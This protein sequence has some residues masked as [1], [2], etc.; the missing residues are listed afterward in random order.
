MFKKI[1][2]LSTVAIMSVS[3][4]VF[5]QPAMA[6]KKLVQQVYGS[7][8]ADYELGDYKSALKKLER[9]MK[10]AD[11]IE[12][13]PFERSQ[14][15]LTLAET[16]RSLGKYKEAEKNFNLS[17]EWALK[18]G[19]KK[20]ITLSRVYNNMA[21]L[22][23]ENG[24]YAKAE[25]SWL[26]AEEI[27]GNF[28]YLPVNNLCRLYLTWGKLKEAEKYLEEAKKYSKGR[29][30]KRTVS[31]AY[32]YFNL[33][34]YKKFKGDYKGA[35][36][37]F[38]KSIDSMKN[39]LSKTHLY[40]TLV[41]AGM[42]DLYVSQSRFEKAE[43]TNRTIL[44]TRQTTFGNENPQVAEAMVNLANVLADQGKFGEARK[45]AKQATEINKKIFE[46]GENLFVANALH[47]LGNIS[48]LE[49]RYEDAA[50]LLK[51]TLAMEE[52]ILG[53]ELLQIA[54]TKR[55]LARV[56]LDQSDYRGAEALFLAAAKTVNSLTGPDHPE[57]A[58]LSRDLGN[59]YL[60][61][62]MYDK[63]ETYYLKALELARTVLGEKNRVTADSAR[64]LGDLYSKKGNNE[65]ALQYLTTARD[66]DVSLYGEDAPQVAADLMAMATIY[67]ALG[68]GSEATPLIAKASAIKQKVAGGAPISTSPSL[69]V[70]VA[71][72]DDSNIAVREKWALAIGISNFKDPSI[73]LK[74]AA[75]DATDFS[76]F[77]INTEKFKKDHVKLLTDEQATRQNIIDML[78]KKWLGQRAHKNDLI[79][80]YVSSHGSRSQQDAGGV[81]FLVAHDTDKN[82]LL[83]TGIPMQWLTKMI[84][85]QVQS[86]RV[87]L[88]LDVCHS[89]AAAQGGK[90][91]HRIT[92]MTQ[93][94]NM[95]IGSGQMVLCSSRAEQVSWESK[96]YENSVFTR[97]L[98]EALRVNKE[99]TS[100]LEAY[101]R[102]KILVES[103]VLRDRS[104]LQ[105]P[106]LWNKDWKGKDPVLAV[107][108][109]SE[110]KTTD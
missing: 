40:Y 57:R 34:S 25:Q 41:L 22:Y 70:P 23:Y 107:D 10:L 108:T 17:E 81:N 59:L 29:I 7:A 42:S 98:I 65:K 61:E 53:E 92:G 12:F 26:K 74:Y 2:I 66:I 75:K 5:P 99:E 28:R 4:T 39:L 64:D 21:V 102:L 80:V 109:A 15:L 97:R 36:E 85:E 84:K 45:Y 1:A 24:Q 104:N 38:K 19:R 90:G 27:S 54:K 101:K 100:L 67:D 91:L 73:N 88:I 55:D 30:T 86:D 8:L 51:E 110:S 35:E 56:K 71:F 31:E 47:S 96:K 77:L 11:G 16:Q 6:Q 46:D 62:G 32:Y 79:V 95:T 87:V 69:K 18:A 20:N 76:N 44:K 78:G 93:P 14:G 52:R 43:E 68:R 103:E 82:S 94:E 106:V 72:N 50:K 9:A 58:E 63:A 3:G 60:R 33:A 13:T 48:R 83:A 49:G 89:G 37:D 105:T